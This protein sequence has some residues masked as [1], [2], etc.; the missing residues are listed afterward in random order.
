MLRR[1]A[2]CVAACLAMSIA[3]AASA[4]VVGATTADVGNKTNLVDLT[5][6]YGSGDVTLRAKD[7]IGIDLVHFRSSASTSVVLKAS[8]DTTPP[9]GQRAALLDGDRALN[10]GVINPG[11]GSGLS[12]DPTAT[13][14]GFGVRFTRPVVNGPGID[15]V[16]VDFDV[17]T[18]PA[19]G[20]GFV[21]SPIDF[22]PGGLA[23]KTF[24]NGDYDTSVVVNDGY[25]LAVTGGYPI[26]LSKVE[27]NALSN[28]GTAVQD[29]YFTGID[30]SDL[31]YAA[32][33]TAAGL[34]FQGR[35]SGD[36]V[37]PMFIAGLPRGPWGLL[38]AATSTSGGREVLDS[39]TVERGVGR[40]V[41]PGS[42]LIGIDVIHFNGA[43]TSAL[44]V[45][46][47]ETSVPTG[48]RAA[49]LD[50]D[51]ALNSGLI[52]PGRAAYSGTWGCTVDPVLRLAGGTG[53]DGAEGMGFVFDEPVVN[54]PG[55]DV[56]LF[57]LDNGGTLDSGDGFWLSPLHFEAGLHSFLYT[58]ADYD[59][60]EPL[61]S[62]RV[63]T[64]AATNT[65]DDIET[66]AAGLG[67]AASSFRWH[68][69]GIDLSDLGYARWASATGLFLQAADPS[70]V[71]DPVLIVGLQAIPEP[72]T[73][74]LL[75]LGA[76]GLLRRR[77][78]RR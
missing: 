35:T 46:G 59:L 54:G 44:A 48:T 24:N 30:L 33:A 42:D 64:L 75:G 7:L 74:A 32:G 3:A 78:R 5:V 17:A 13:T 4:G 2:V 40:E 37:D 8:G 50:G 51:L 6:D 20:D 56:I 34:F 57:E 21:V 23:A 49:L 28:A 36:L 63:G 72:A 73:L 76:L 53:P 60:F 43:T 45:P 1:P 38:G 14:E 77:R 47:S 27:N 66:S 25:V 62:F 29:A 67:S 9:A 58:G 22:S 19:P 12:S 70:E 39:V 61:T 26:T 52:N 11:K 16:F 31:G 71:I 69:I 55:I 10:T 15:V 41:I 65:I 18:D 68:A